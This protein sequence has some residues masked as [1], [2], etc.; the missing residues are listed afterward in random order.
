MPPHASV[1]A[2]SLDVPRLFESRTNPSRAVYDGVVNRRTRARSTITLPTRRFPPRGG[3]TVDGL[4]AHV[5]QCRAQRDGKSPCRPTRPSTRSTRSI[6]RMRSRRSIER[7]RRDRRDRSIGW[8]RRDRS[9]IDRVRSIERVDRRDRRDRS[10]EAI[11]AFD[12]SNPIDRSNLDRSRSHGAPCDDREIAA[13][14]PQSVDRLTSERRSID[15][16][17][18]IDRSETETGCLP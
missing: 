10:I 3:W 17:A 5:A 16:R 2:G 13:V 6:D 8:D 4:R 14:Q 12:R 18:S 15:L 11:D 1:R 7:D 9:T